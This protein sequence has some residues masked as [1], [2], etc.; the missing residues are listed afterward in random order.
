[1]SAHSITEA[2]GRAKWLAGTLV[3]LYALI[4]MIP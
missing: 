4:T 3:I 1:M 2:S